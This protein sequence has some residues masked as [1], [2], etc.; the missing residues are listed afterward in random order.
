MR[1][2]FP[3]GGCTPLAGI[4]EVYEKGRALATTPQQEYMVHY[5]S[6]QMPTMY[7]TS[8]TP[9]LLVNN[10]S[11]FVLDIPTDQWKKELRSW[12]HFNLAVLQTTITHLAAG[13]G[14]VRSDFD[15]LVEPLEW[16]GWCHSQRMAAP[17]G[18]SNVNVL[19]LILTISI[20]SLII[21][22][23]L[24]IVPSFKTLSR[25]NVVSLP[26]I[27]GWIQ[28]GML[29]VLRKAYEATDQIEW[30][31]LEGDVPVARKNP[32]I[33]VFAIQSSG[34]KSMEACNVIA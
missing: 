8:A 3:Q 25:R 27:K 29:Q 23:N 5:L 1:F 16:P 12:F 24:T 22:A 15:Q 30:Q 14:V 11:P 28:D 4:N 17:D 13:P 31:R 20:S 2:C 26:S 19:G 21:A 6:L 7:Y 18:Y 33:P 9:M 10:G 32:L 34:S